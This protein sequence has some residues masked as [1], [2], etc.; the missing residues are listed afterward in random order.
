MGPVP[1]SFPI[2]LWV[3]Q[4]LLALTMLGAGGFKLVTP[5][6]KIAEKLKWCATWTDRNVKLLGLAEVL[7]AIGLIVPSVTGI[8]PILTPIAA[9][10]LA[11]LMVGAVKTHVDLDESPLPAAIP[12]ALA[13]LIAAGRLAVPAGGG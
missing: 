9:A 5:R 1:P 11:I 8:L 6:L 3:S 2:I 12:L 10:C 13:I 7:G 4:G